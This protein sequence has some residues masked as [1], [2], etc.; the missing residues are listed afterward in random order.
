MEARKK[1]GGRKTHEA[2]E[3]EGGIEPR[4]TV[5]PVEACEGISMAL[6]AAEASVVARAVREVE[7]GKRSRLR[8]NREKDNEELKKRKRVLHQ[9]VRQF[10]FECARLGNQLSERGNG[11]SGA[12]SYARVRSRGGTERGQ[13]ETGADSDDRRCLFFFALSPRSSPARLDQKVVVL[14]L[15]FLALRAGPLC[16]ISITQRPLSRVRS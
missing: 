7:G 14:F 13:E 1:K 11:R 12:A 6:A 4:R 3:E 8:E 10:Y 16:L 9:S 15:F 5:E 2:P